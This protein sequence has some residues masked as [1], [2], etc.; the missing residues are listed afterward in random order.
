MNWFDCLLIAIVALYLIGGF[1]RG[2]VKQL[3]SLFGFFI[4]LAL[5][6]AG[7][8][9][10]GGYAAAFIDPQCLLPYREAAARLGADLPVETILNLVA[11]VLTFLAFLIILQILFRLIARTMTSINRVPVIGFFNRLGGA[12]LGLL[13]GVVFAYLLVAIVSLVPVK[14]CTEAVGGSAAAA[15]AEQYLPPVTEGLKNLLV[16]FYLQAVEKGA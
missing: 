10:L 15:L 13:A 7:S 2:F 8:R 12:A 9:L 5:A 16:E 6:F 14:F 11:G 3:F 1:I 4:I